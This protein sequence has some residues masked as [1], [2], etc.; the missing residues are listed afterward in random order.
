MPPI[1]GKPNHTKRRSLQLSLFA[2][3]LMT[4]GLWKFQSVSG[5]GMVGEVGEVAEEEV[6]EPGRCPQHGSFPTAG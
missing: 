4:H 5:A 6:E 3:W 1:L 2:N